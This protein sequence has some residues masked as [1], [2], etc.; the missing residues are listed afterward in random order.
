MESALVTKVETVRE[1]V[2]KL[3]LKY[4]KGVPVYAEWNKQLMLYGLGAL[5]KYDV[6]YDIEE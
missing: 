5:R 3:V 1:P 6:L 4:G 2:N